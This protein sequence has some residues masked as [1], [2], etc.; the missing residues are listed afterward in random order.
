MTKTVVFYADDS[1]VIQDKDT[2]SLKELA[3]FRVKQTAE[4]TKV[5]QLLLE[6]GCIKSRKPIVLKRDRYSLACTQGK[7]A[8]GYNRSDFV[9]DLLEAYRQFV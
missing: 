7:P 5:F 8:C 9:N 1:I 2:F 4:G 6:R 3:H